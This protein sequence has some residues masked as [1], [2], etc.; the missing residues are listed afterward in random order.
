MWKRGIDVLV[1]SALD[2]SAIAETA[3]EKEDGRDQGL[4]RVYPV[5]IPT[6]TIITEIGVAE[7][8]FTITQIELTIIT[9]GDAMVMPDNS[10]LFTRTKIGNE[11][12]FDSRDSDG[13]AI[14]AAETF[15]KSLEFGI[16]SD[17]PT[18]FPGGA[19]P[20]PSTPV[21]V[22]LAVTAIVAGT[23]EEADDTEMAT[24]T[25]NEENDPVELAGLD[26][27]RMCTASVSPDD[28]VAPF[29]SDIIENVPVNEGGVTVN[30]GRDDSGIARDNSGLRIDL[31]RTFP[32]TAADGSTG[33]LTLTDSLVGENFTLNASSNVLLE[34][35]AVVMTDL[36][37]S[38]GRSP[39][40]SE[41]TRRITICISGDDIPPTKA[42]RNIDAVP[43][44]TQV[45]LRFDSAYD[46]IGSSADSDDSN[47]MYTRDVDYI[48]T[49]TRLASGDKPMLTFPSITIPAARAIVSETG[50]GLDLEILSSRPS[51]E[52]IPIEILLTRSDV[53][54]LPKDAYMV[55]ILVRDDADID[56]DES[57]E[58]DFTML[59]NGAYAELAALNIDCSAGDNDGIASAYE[60]HI[61]T[62]CNGSVNDYLGSTLP[63]S[64]AMIDVP[65]VPSTDNVYVVEAGISTYTRIVTRDVGTLDVVTCEAATD[66]DANTPRDE[67]NDCNYL[68]AFIVS[69]GLTGDMTVD[70]I[71]IVTDIC[72]DPDSVDIS[73]IPNSCWVDNVSVD[74]DGN[75]GPIPL[76]LGY[77]VIE[78]VAADAWDNLILGTRE[79]QLVY[80]APAVELDGA[81][82]L[83]L[84]AATGT[85]K[86]RVQFVYQD[87]DSISFIG[88]NR[89][90]SDVS[91]M[92]TR[93]CDPASAFITVSQLTAGAD[94]YEYTA[95]STGAAT[96][97]IVA[98][99]TSFGDNLANK[100]F[101][102]AV[103]EITVERA[104][105]TTNR[106]VREN[107]RIDI[108]GIVVTDISSDTTV[109]AVVSGGN[110][111][112]A[113][114]GAEVGEVRA[115]PQNELLEPVAGIYTIR[116]ELEG[117]ISIQAIIAGAPVTT[118]TYSIL[119][120]NTPVANITDTDNDGVPDENDNDGNS[121]P[122]NERNILLSDRATGATIEVPFGY[123]VALGNN[124][125]RNG[126]NQ[127]QLGQDRNDPD[128]LIPDSSDLPENYNNEGVFEFTVYLPANTNTAYVSIPLATALTENKGYVKYID[129]DEDGNKEWVDFSTSGGDAYYSARR[130]D[131]G[132]G[133]ITCPSPALGPQWERPENKL[134]V[135]GHQCVLLVI[136][137]DGRDSN[138]ELL[139]DVDR[140]LNGIIV[141]P[142]APG[143]AGGPP[144][145]GG[146][147]ATDLWFLLMLLGLVA[148]PVLTR[149]RKR[150]TR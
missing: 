81:I 73:S 62:D 128:T 58:A 112:V 16:D 122:H 94:T 40:A 3:I 71:A 96:C 37:F 84:S 54:L 114:D 24:I 90:I 115:L 127:A 118:Q 124:A 9:G 57:Y 50:L 7:N 111:R 10:S 30:D 17:E 32:L 98:E 22:E 12:T 130:T 18:G 131:D 74:E 97:N 49:I 14:A 143:T 148:V 125:R 136:T 144:S 35:D 46:T 103:N 146:G 141:D 65:T 121:L 86:F 91:M 139:N 66:D 78:W 56:S 119:P 142:G 123:R 77:S 36:T 60:L 27:N 13:V 72:T 135:A 43:G 100:P 41:E 19:I 1:L 79:K 140:Q 107:E 6:D 150:L 45:T 129:R 126:H 89:S 51:P 21:T 120:V 29:G 116:P 92:F 68:K 47:Y 145:R 104:N 106:V 26:N 11:F 33:T 75:V 87:G 147:G 105:E 99:P 76:Q 5:A 48:I 59:P 95:T 70:P 64:T 53:A 67:R 133:V 61:G 15:I 4:I 25:I 85:G 117:S 137:D 23:S 52:F 44:A 83:D 63:T 113:S 39:T 8:T 38:D 108:N 2:A 149:Q 138:G 93:N 31:S 20:A 42:G 132:S 109:S 34:D 134:L 55:E 80:V 82:D 110:Y 102:F 101:Y 69:S 88:T 28:L